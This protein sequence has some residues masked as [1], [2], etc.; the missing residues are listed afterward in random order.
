MLIVYGKKEECEISE[1]KSKEIYSKL[2]QKENG[3]LKYKQKDICEEYGLPSWFVSNFKK[4]KERYTYRYYP[5]P[6][7][8]SDTKNEIFTLID[9]SF[10]LYT[11]GSTGNLTEIYLYEEPYVLLNVSESNEKAKKWIQSNFGRIQDKIA[12]TELTDIITRDEYDKWYKNKNTKKVEVKHSYPSVA[13]LQDIHNRIKNE[14]M[15]I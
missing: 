9:T 11:N 12:S 7:L 1:S 13:E 10:F 6:K 8:R 15:D 5:E 2:T 3:R 14:C 4:T